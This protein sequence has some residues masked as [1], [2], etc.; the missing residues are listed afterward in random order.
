M[1]GKY[2]AVF[3][4]CGFPSFAMAYC[5]EPSAPSCATG[6]GSFDGEWEFDSCKR[7]MESYQ[8]EVEAFY[9]CNKRQA[10]E[11]VDKAEEART[12]AED[13]I[14]KAK[15]ANERATSDYNDAV[16]SFNRKAGG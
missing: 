16:Q 10:Q 1:I 9:Q 11:F 8:S 5:S 12:E 3:A 2:L 14:Q 6:Y 13:E 4:F 7:D 15:S